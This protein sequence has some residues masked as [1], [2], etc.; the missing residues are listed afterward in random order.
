LHGKWTAS[1]S[2]RAYWGFPGAKAL[3]D[4][5]G[6]QSPPRSFALADPGY[7][8]AYGPSVFWNAGLEYRPT[9]H[10]T[11]RADAF[12]ILGWA[13]QTLNKRIYYFRGSDYSSE[14]ASVAL[15]VKLTF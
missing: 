7:D 3:A 10:L 9:K 13:D 15:S 11:V 5:N 4:W 2:L 8:A 6:A 12:N 14:A 1:T